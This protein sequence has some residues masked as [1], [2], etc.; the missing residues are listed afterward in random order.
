MDDSTKALTKESY[1][2]PPMG[3]FIAETG[4][5]GATT[6]LLYF[7]KSRGP[8]E[9]L[10]RLKQRHLW[11]PVISTSSPPSAPKSPSI[12]PEIAAPTPS[13]PPPSDRG[14]VATFSPIAGAH[15]R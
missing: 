15:K 3:Y 6:V 4:V 11:T 13:V 1:E 7:I 9:A 14:E 12:D 8:E 10:H 2:R 5:P